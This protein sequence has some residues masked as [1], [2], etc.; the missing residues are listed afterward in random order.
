[1]DL[2]SSWFLTG[3]AVLAVGSVVAT[4]VLWSRLAGSDPAAGSAGPGSWSLVQ[5][6]GVAL[7]AGLVNAQNDFYPTLGSLL[8]SRARL[9][10]RPV[11]SARVR[12]GD[13]DVRER[14]PDRDAPPGPD[15]VRQP[16]AGPAQRVVPRRHDPGRD[17][18][19]LRQPPHGQRREGLAAPAVRP[20]LASAGR[21]SPCVMVLTGYPG[22][23]NA[24]WRQAHIPQVAA[25]A[26]ARHAIP[27]FILLAV[28]P[29]VAPPRDTECTDVHGR[30]GGPD[31]PAQRR[32]HRPA[33]PVRRP[34]A[35][36]AAG[37]SWGTPPAATARPCWPCGTQASSTRG[38]P[39]RVLHPDH[40]LHHRQPGRRQRAA[41]GPAQPDVAP[42]APARAV[43]PPA[44]VRRDGGPSARVPA[45]EALAAA[46]RPPTSVSTLVAARRWAQL[47]DLEHADTAGPE[48]DR[49]AA[50]RVRRHHRGCRWQGGLV[51]I[52]SVEGDITKQDVDAIVN[53]AN[54]TLLGG[55]GVDGAIHAA[56]G[57]ALLEECRRLRRTDVAGRPARGPRGRDRGRRAA[58]ALGHPH[59]RAE[60]AP[61]AGRPGP[62]GLVLHRQPRR[63]GRDR[64]AV[65]GLPGDQ[66]GRLRL[67]T[68]RTSPGS[69]ST[70]YGAGP[71]PAPTPA[72]RWTSCGSCCSARGPPRR[73]RTRWLRLD[74][75]VAADESGG[76]M[77]VAA[78]TQAWHRPAEVAV[79]TAVLTV[80]CRTR[81]QAA[82]PDSEAPDEHHRHDPRPRRGPS[83]A[84]RRRR[85]AG[86]GVGRPAGRAGRVRRTA[87]PL[88]AADC[89]RPIRTKVAA[90]LAAAGL[91]VGGAAGAVVGHSTAPWHRSRPGGPA[92]S[93]PA[94]RTVR[95]RTGRV[96][97]VRVRTGSAASAA[98]ASRASRASRGPPLRA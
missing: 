35:A 19:R 49:P 11:R 94:G 78:R 58:R 47:D 76:P 12:L 2:T 81:H 30:P 60:P 1:M 51:L 63:G 59:R 69:P 89:P 74:E 9:G 16:V 52:E 66:R 21:S 37:R 92:S 38:Q 4:L 24:W 65:G 26:I 7:L 3:L 41:P 96:R 98:P 70:P 29:D 17:A 44:A 10:R 86:V 15:G 71:A 85:P 25:A 93:A 73:S 75:R 28:N 23:T 27:P 13:L 53:A 82:L 83:G 43:R 56:A 14:R 95:V 57:P 77:G 31:L 33:A 62:A 55:G 36:G 22:N 61:R 45:L 64:R 97:T 88:A 90:L 50:A 39:G 42:G 54:S 67:G 68:S 91:V 32:A 5:V 18:G 72:R 8:G 84:G 80:R 48:V 87:G 34:T 46:A 20:R 6:T 40:R 79:T